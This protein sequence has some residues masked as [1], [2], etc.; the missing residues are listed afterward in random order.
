MYA[1]RGH[2]KRSSYYSD[3]TFGVL[4]E[5][6]NLVPIGKAYT[7]FTDLELLKLDKFVRSN[8]VGRFGPVREVN[9]TLVVEVAF[10]KIMQ[11]NR[12]KSGIAM[13][14]PRFKR[15]RW[16]KPVKEVEPL[17]KIMDEFL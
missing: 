13:R 8:T 14:F 6:G 9:K 12:H 11:S 5:V 3:F 15:I 17:E 1:Q 10:D 4:N 7:G 16:D 2:G